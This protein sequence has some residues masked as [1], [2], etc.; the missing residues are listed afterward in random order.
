[1]QSWQIGVAIVGLVIVIEIILN[2][3]WNVPYFRVGI[4]IFARR[5]EKTGGIAAID[6]D[7]LEKTTKTAAGAPLAFRRLGPDLIAFRER[8]FGGYIPMMRGVIRSTAE[9]PSIAVA[10]LI[11]WSVIAVAV[12]LVVFLRR[13]V[14]DVAPYF[15]GLLAVLYF[16]QA[17]RFNRV[18]TKL[19]GPAHPDEKVAGA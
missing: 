2:W 8:A 3:K 10:G 13:G 12:V 6:L 4:P 14:L 19:R 9:E 15:L 5:I 11:H 18:A 7:A 16:I 17:V 1:M